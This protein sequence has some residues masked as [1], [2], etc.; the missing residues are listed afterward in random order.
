MDSSRKFIGVSIGLAILLIIL[1]SCTLAYS[2]RDNTL[3]SEKT[4]HLE[5]NGYSF[6]APLSENE[7]AYDTICLTSVHPNVFI[8]KNNIGATVKI[9]DKVIG[10][11]KTLE[12]ELDEL[13]VNKKIKI[14]VDNEKDHRVIYIRT[15]SSQMPEMLV[16]GESVY[17]G[18]YY[19]ILSTGTALYELNNQ[20]KVVFYI[21]K[22]I[23]QEETYSDFKKHVLEDETIRYSYQRIIKNK[24][25]SISIND[26]QGERVI[27][28][29]NYKEIK[30]LQLKK[31]DTVQS[32]EELNGKDFIMLSDDHYILV[33][34]QM[35]IVDNI[36]ADLESNPLGS[37][38]ISTL[39]QEVNEDEIVFE[40]SSDDFSELYGLSVNNNDYTNTISQNPDYMGFSSM[41]IDP[42]DENLICSFTNLNTIIKINRETGSIVWKLSGDLDQFGLTADQ[43]MSGQTQI[44]VTDKG[45]FVI[46]DNG[47]ITKKTRLLKIKLDEA[48]KKILEYIEYTVPGHQ[49]IAG[50]NAK[51]IGDN[52]EVYAIGWGINNDGLAVLTEM[53]FN[54]GRKLFEISFPQGVFNEAIQKI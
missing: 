33:G 26:T 34:N 48:N 38:I 10:I 15:I 50:G 1:V 7:K 24:D 35:K 4:V 54:S 32:E 47:I 25:T 13:S 44:D 42:V 19:G 40:F 39:I 22:D 53:D 23:D 21:A 12:V 31:S 36:P 46:F 6:E 49:S 52:Q 9:N 37:K 45:Y 18:N 30:T 17:N 14:E 2:G 41:V 5:I 28:D 8:L 11:G 43:K 20:G 3:M 16:A 51:K 29:E 27:L